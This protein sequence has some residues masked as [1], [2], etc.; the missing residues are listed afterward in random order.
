MR[1]VRDEK[2]YYFDSLDLYKRVNVSNPPT[3]H[4][5]GHKKFCDTLNARANAGK[6]EAPGGALAPLVNPAKS[7]SHFI[8]A[9]DKETGEIQE[10]TTKKDGSFFEQKF[11]ENDGIIK[12]EIFNENESIVKREIRF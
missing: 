3:N 12:R 6:S 11:D 4:I 7:Q 1:L 10:F 5:P 8:P 9:I 2:Q